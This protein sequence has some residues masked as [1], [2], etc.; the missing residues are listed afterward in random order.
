MTVTLESL[1]LK[2]SCRKVRPIPTQ[3]PPGSPKNTPRKG[4][5]EQPPLRPTMPAQSNRNLHIFC[6]SRFCQQ[7][8]LHKAH[9]ASHQH[10]FLPQWRTKEQE[11]SKRSSECACWSCWA[12]W[13]C[14]FS[15]NHCNLAEWWLKVTQGTVFSFKRHATTWKLTRQTKK[16]S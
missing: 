9:P 8:K 13:A 12:C 16:E 15:R 4:P 7:G 6:S 5:S 11:I 2:R 14:W 3:W 1:E 10:M